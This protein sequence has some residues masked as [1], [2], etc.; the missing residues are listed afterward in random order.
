MEMH[1]KSRKERAVQPGRVIGL[2]RTVGLLL[3]VMTGAG[4]ACAETLTF[5]TAD[6][7]LAGHKNQGWWSSGPRYGAIP[8]GDNYFV[9]ALEG[10][11]LRCFFTFDLAALDVAGKDVV[12]ARLEVTRYEF[13][14]PYGLEM[15]GLF[16]VSTDAVI[17]NQKS[18]TDLTIWEDLGSGTN[19]GLFP[20]TPL[21][22]IYDRWQTAVYDLNVAAL[23]DIQ[24]A[25]GGFFSIGGSL[26]GVSPGDRHRCTFSASGGGGVQQLV[27][28]TAVTYESLAR[29]TRHLVSNAGGVRSQQIAESLCHTLELA[30]RAA[31]N[32]NVNLKQ[33]M[34]KVY[35]T[36]V[37]AEQ[38]KTLTPE[39]VATLIGLASEL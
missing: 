16:D 1:L 31:S 5:T 23:A 22:S 38:G 10:D 17:L 14:S 21:V 34:L 37:K 8:P 19:Y 20:V 11:I 15:L 28:E 25:A 13:S 32:G 29:L 6:H 3:W 39:N 26:Q 24:A 35:A 36:R 18:G 2:W 4:N 30:Q 9:G 33:N 12:A 27:I 7:V